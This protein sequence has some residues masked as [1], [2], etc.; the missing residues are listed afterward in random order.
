MFQLMAGDSQ[1]DD[2]EEL[3]E[4]RL[5]A[6]VLAKAGLIDD[7]GVQDGLVFPLPKGAVIDEIV[8]T[9]DSRESGAMVRCAVCPQRQAHYDG[10]RVALKSG[11]HV[12][13]GWRCGELTFRQDWKSAH[14]GFQRKVEQT[15]FVGRVKPT[16]DMLAKVEPL[17]REWHGRAKKLGSW[18]KG[19][20]RELPDLWKHLSFVAAS[21]ERLLASE[22]RLGRIPFAAMFTGESP[23]HGLNGALRAIDDARD[24]LALGTDS[25]T[26]AKAFKLVQQARFQLNEA[27]RAHQGAI[28]NLN[29]DW[30]REMCSWAN[31]SFDSD[32]GYWLEGDA[33][34]HTERASQERFEVLDRAELGTSSLDAVL[35][36]WRG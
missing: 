17:I 7:A 20:Q 32:A 31:R 5:T 36:E 19:F 16:L 8:A 23:T 14:A 24:L 2:G 35:A 21:Q 10:F 26:L 34:V 11:E 30:L 25:P 3:L 15:K 22:P 13:M 29:P 28:A 18:L 4:Q 33:I 27:H 12:R 6:E 9:Y 1:D